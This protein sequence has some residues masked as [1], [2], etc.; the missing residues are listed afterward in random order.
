MGMFCPIKAPTDQA[1]PFGKMFRSAHLYIFNCIQ[2]FQK[3]TGRHVCTNVFLGYLELNLKACV[4][5]R[6]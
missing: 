2:F 1:I 4:K 3:A 5:L 6:I